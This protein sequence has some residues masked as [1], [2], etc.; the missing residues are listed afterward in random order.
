M[1]FVIAQH[2][3][4]TYKSHLVDLLAKKTSLSVL[5]ATNGRRIE[6]GNIYVT[7]RDRESEFL[8]SNTEFTMREVTI[9]NKKFVLNQEQATGS[10]GPKPSIDNLFR[11][12][13]ADRGKN[14]VGI[15]LSGSGKDGAEGVSAI[16]QSGGFTMIQEPQ[17]AE[18]ERMPI[19]A[20]D[21]G[22][23]DYVLP[24]EE[25]GNQ[26][27][28]M[29]EDLLSLDEHLVK[30]TNKKETLDKIFDLLSKRTET[31]FEN[32]SPSTIYRRLHKRLAKLN[33]HSF[34]DYLKLIK[35]DPAEIDAL[36]DTILIGVTGFFRDKESFEQL[37]KQLEKAISRKASG[38]TIR[39]WTPGCTTGEEPY[40]IAIILYRI[41][42]YKISRYNIQIFATDIDEKAL[43][44]GRKGVYSKNTLRE[45]DSTMVDDYFTKKGTEYWLINRY[46]PCGSLLPKRPL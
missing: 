39:I 1:A 10:T 40:S 44:K 7:P 2:L 30:S 25:M 46:G 24:P 29:A 4:P 41:L 8:S 16:K 21:T 38:D 11:S 26:I 9:K 33:I 17:T 28:E 23:V 27:Q 13:A 37:E 36:F 5:P 45:L 20:I 12:L 43:A 35:E 18:Y 32:Y 31:N 22:F 6:Q 14:V 15:V 34:D 19:A 42:K 3:S